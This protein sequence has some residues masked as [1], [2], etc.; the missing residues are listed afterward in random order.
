MRGIQEE[1]NDQWYQMQR[2]DQ[3]DRGKK[4]VAGYWLG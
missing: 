4:L 3:E 2:K 1:Q